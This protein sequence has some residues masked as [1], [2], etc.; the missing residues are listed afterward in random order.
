MFISSGFVTNASLH[1]RRSHQPHHS[2]Q[3]EVQGGNKAHQLGKPYQIPHSQGPG[4][5]FGSKSSQLGNVMTSTQ[6]VVTEGS[7]VG[8]FTDAANVKE[9]L[10]GHALAKM[11]S[12]QSYHHHNSFN[13]ICCKYP[14][15]IK[16]DVLL[17]LLDQYPKKESAQ[18]LR[19]GFSEGF[20]LGYQGPRVGR[21]SRNLK[22]ALQLHEKIMEKIEKE[23][24]HFKCHQ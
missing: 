24:N 19:E 3:P 8:S 14:S 18:I 22:S 23:M 15:P 4:V 6:Q 1:T 17:P 12:N 11:G 21:E 7:N 2:Q 9:L 10:T 5:Q 13:C 20:R 16:L